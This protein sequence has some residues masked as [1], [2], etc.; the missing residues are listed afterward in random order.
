MKFTG[1]ENGDVETLLNG[2]D[3]MLCKGSKCIMILYA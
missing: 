2:E 3:K 1:S